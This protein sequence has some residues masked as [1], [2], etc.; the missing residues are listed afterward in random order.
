V[1]AAVITMEQLGK[2]YSISERRKGEGLRHAIQNAL[3]FPFR[4]G[5]GEQRR[6]SEEFWALHDVSCAIHPGEVVGLV[7]R[8]G[9]GKSTVLKILSR[10]TEPTRGTVRMRGRI[11]S[12][13]E[14]G[15]GFHPDLSGRENVFLNGALLGMRRAE[16]RARFDEMVA[17]AE[18]EKFIDTPVK[19]YSSG[20]YVRLAF[21]VAAHLEPE[22]LLVDEVLAVG[23]AAFQKKC[24]GKMGEISKRQGRTVLFVSHSM[25][26]VTQLCTRALLLEG[27]T[28]KHDGSAD[29]VIAEYLRSCSEGSGLLL[30]K[31]E[32]EDLRRRKKLFF[33]S[34]QLRDS[35]GSSSTD[36]DVRRPFSV[37]LEYE[38]PRPLN[39]VE[40]SA[41][42]VTS[43]GRPVLTS[44]RSELAPDALDQKKEGRYEA[45]IQFPGMFFMPGTY[46]INVAAHHPV[47]EIFDLQENAVQFTIQ[48]TGT[49]FAPYRDY[50]SIGVVLKELPWSER[51]L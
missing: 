18:V 20:M 33:T 44:L 6:R 32:V 14:V 7:G 27:G 38:V 15:T 29:K 50:Q 3:E 34:V 10:I 5:R 35:A 43:D 13:L 42:V 37:R 4:L 11:A 17:F 28:L 24:L 30:V 21:A 39:R 31:E 1:N 51:K 46:F 16:I 40:L 9:A 23:D 19:R 48:D 47:G 41:R 26:V 22:I 8:N 12:L 45:E 25:P 2:R 36:L 49:H